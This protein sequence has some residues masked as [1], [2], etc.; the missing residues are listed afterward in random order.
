MCFEYIFQRNTEEI[1]AEEIEDI[2]DK[3][4]LH[5]IKT[6]LNVMMSCL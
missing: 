1:A 4:T 2:V 3:G 5:Y 6:V